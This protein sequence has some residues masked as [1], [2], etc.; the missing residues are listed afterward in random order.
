MTWATSRAVARSEREPGNPRAA[1]T[2][3][4]PRRR[5]PGLGLVG[6]RLALG[7]VAFA[8]AWLGQTS[9]LLTQNGGFDSGA[10][11]WS[12]FGGAEIVATAEPGDD[13]FARVPDGGVVLLYQEVAVSAPA[14][15]VAFDFFTG[16]MAGGFPSP[17][18]FPDT[19][20]VTVYSGV[21]AAD[22]AP[23]QFQSDGAIG[24]LEYDAVNGLRG[25]SPG[26]GIGA[27][28]ARPGWSRLEGVFATIPGQP[29]LA[30]TFQNLDG[31]G[32]RG[33]SAWLV[34]NVQVVAV[35][36]MGNGFAAAAGCAM[37]ALWSLGRGCRKRAAAA[38]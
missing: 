26:T 4:S 36:E 22:L 31:N 14:F 16:L 33:D 13:P 3:P 12:L 1:E 34:D 38:R 18:G 5:A 2:R 28:G 37:L 25:T 9:T 8:Q 20:F 32:V 15:R 21:T 11:G 17:G 6:L 23:E 7:S 10:V 30:L 24:L 19:A 27:N 35:P 29:F